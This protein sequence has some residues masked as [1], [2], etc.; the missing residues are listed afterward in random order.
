MCWSE[1]SEQPRLHV[2]VAVLVLELLQDLVDVAVLCDVRF[3]V[4]TS[5]HKLL[6][7]IALLESA[8][9]HLDDKGGD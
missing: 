5:N 8:V 7:R 4:G 1:A 6:V 9:E 3:P 2:L